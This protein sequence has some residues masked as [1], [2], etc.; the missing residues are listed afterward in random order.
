MLIFENAPDQLAVEFGNIKLQTRRAAEIAFIDSND[1]IQYFS[2]NRKRDTLIIFSST[3]YIEIFHLYRAL[4]DLYFYVKSGDTVLFTYDENKYPVL[5]SYTS[6]LLTQQYNFLKNIPN[7]LSYFGFNPLSLLWE[8]NFWRIYRAKK[9]NE[10]VPE[11][12]LPLYMPMDTVEQQANTYPQNYASLLGKQYN[13]KKISSDVYNYYN[14]LLLVKTI[15]KKRDLLLNNPINLQQRSMAILNQI[16]DGFFNDEY[17][18]YISYF[19]NIDGYLLAYKLMGGFPFIVVG[20]GSYCDYRIMF[21]SLASR[22]DIPPKTHAYMLSKTLDNIMR[23]FSVKDIEHYAEKYVVLTGNSLRT[24]NRLL[25]LGITE[26]KND[27][28]QLND[29]NGNMIAF[30]TILGQLKGNVIYLNF[31]ASW[32]VPCRSAMPEAFKLRKEYKDKDVAFVYL[33]FN[34]REDT[35]KKAVNDLR[36]N[37]GRA[38][39]FFIINS[40]SSKAIQELK[41]E[42]VPHY[43]IYDKA[44]K[45]VHHNA[46]SPNK[47]EIRKMLD[48]LLK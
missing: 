29:K 4:E 28:I 16:Y 11:T 48:E 41:I 5:K 26:T 40:K 18:R 27:D 30:E 35:W 32:C 42:S 8:S 2:P 43:L 13:E 24:K 23:Y 38:I 22:V 31:W 34:D 17:C 39:N 20:S 21:D 12:L 9:R 46:P 3:D 7:R 45:I 47:T 10:F 6:E 44:G 36:L 19:Y 15:N 25:E 33:A 14:Y 37:D 1:L